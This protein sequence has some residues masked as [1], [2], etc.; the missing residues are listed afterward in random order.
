M[1]KLHGDA[2]Y[3]S[4][5]RN[6]EGCITDDGYV[7]MSR[8]GV[9]KYEHQW[10][11]EERLGRALLPHETVHHKNGCRTDNRPENLELWSSSQPAGQRI[12]DK[13]EWAHMLI[14]LYEGEP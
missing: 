7:R 5:R 10:V 3:T 14:E 9:S 11:M 1:Y 4:R 2:L 12:E 13:L 6:G 8:Q